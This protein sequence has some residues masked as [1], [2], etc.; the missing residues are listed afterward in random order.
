MKTLERCL[1][2]ISVTVSIKRV[3]FGP[4]LFFFCS[5]QCSRLLPSNLGSFFF[6]LFSITLRCL[7]GSV[8]EADAVKVL[9]GSDAAAHDR[10]NGA[11]AAGNEVV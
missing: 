8:H 4:L 6:Y 10:P 1:V 3:D 2:S 5:T 9:A 11:S 7:H